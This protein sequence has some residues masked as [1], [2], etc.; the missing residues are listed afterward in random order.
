MASPSGRIVRPQPPLGAAAVRILHYPVRHLTVFFAIWKALL[1]LVIVACPGPGYDTSTSLLPT[2]ARR[3]AALTPDKWP[4]S[5]LLRFIRWD[6]IYFV[7]IAENGYV[8][9]QEWAFGYGYTLYTITS[10]IRL[11]GGSVNTM[12]VAFVG[13]IVSHI[14][15]YLSVIALYRLSFNIFGRDTPVKKLMCFLSAALHII[16]PAGAFLSAPYGE[17]VFSFLNMFGLYVYSS[18]LFDNC[19]GKTVARDIKLLASAILFAVATSVRSNG[20]LSGFLFACDACSQVWTIGTQ[21]I[22][23]DGCLRLT[24]IIFGGCIV[25]LGLAFP[26]FL[27]YNAYCAPGITSRPWCAWSLP[28]IYSW[29][30]GQYW[31]VGFLRYWT[32]SNI[33]LFL[34]AIPM[35][36]ILCQSSLWGLKL[37]FKMRT[38]FSTIVGPTQTVADSMLMRLAI[39]QGLLAVMALTSYHVQIINRI[40]SGYPLWYWYLASLALDHFGQSEHKTR[41]RS[42]KFAVAVQAMVVYGLIQGVLFGS[43]LPPA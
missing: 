31:N 23:L 2:D 22:S 43:F 21:G 42:R 16:S 28:N 19:H 41:R 3:V 25:G 4:P 10:V 18:S 39:P 20:I 17:P 15:H 36:A 7:H 30:Q 26:Q 5:V 29:V 14:A 12:T 37:S 9:E 24:V 1:F 34:L 8:F 32:V 6:S 35:L 38:G 11:F 13:V 40:S 27:A 33:P